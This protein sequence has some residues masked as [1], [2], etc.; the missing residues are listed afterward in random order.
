M[1]AIIPLLVA[2]QLAKRR[3]GQ[4][5]ASN[6]QQ[7]CALAFTDVLVIELI[8]VGVVVITTDAPLR[9]E[10][11]TGD[12]GPVIFLMLMLALPT[13]AALIAHFTVCRRSPSR[14]A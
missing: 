2:A 9:W 6:P 13:I 4:L 1:G 3:S 12:D 7:P 5:P 8:I 11:A 14:P 10:G